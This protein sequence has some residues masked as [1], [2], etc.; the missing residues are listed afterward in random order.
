[1]KLKKLDIQYILKDNNDNTATHV[2]LK[3]Q[4]FHDWFDTL[5]GLGNLLSTED[6]TPLQLK[7][8]H[9]TKYTGIYD[10]REKDEA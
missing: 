8:I 1:M 10:S 4:D 5:S 6:K 2:I 3:S 9:M 7:L